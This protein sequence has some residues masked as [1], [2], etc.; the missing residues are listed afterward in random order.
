MVSIPR[1]WWAAAPSRDRDGGPVPPVIVGQNWRSGGTQRAL[2]RGV[3]I[4]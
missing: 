4:N 1:A 3:G 2:I